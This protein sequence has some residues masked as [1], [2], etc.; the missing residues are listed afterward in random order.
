MGAKH[1][2]LWNTDTERGDEKAFVAS[3]LTLEIL[4]D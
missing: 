4:L 1:P 3:I 2:A